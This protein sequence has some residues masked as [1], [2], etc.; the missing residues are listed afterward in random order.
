VLHRLDHPHHHLARI[1]LATLLAVSSTASVL[2]ASPAAALE[3]PRPLPG[4]RPAFVTEVQP[5]KWE[6]CLWASAAMLLDKWTS[7]RLGTG[8][9]RLRALSGD[10]VG[11]S[12][13]ADVARAYA[14]VGIPFRY[15]PNGGDR[16]TWAQLLVRLSRGAGAVILGDD[17]ELPRR[18][19]RWDPKFWKK[20]GKD[21]NHA[22]YV[23][24]YDRR[25]GRVWLMDP[26]ARGAWTG[27]WI[28]VR[29]LRRFAWTSGGAVYAATTPTA[30]PAPFAGVRFGAPE[31][32]AGATGLH[33]TWPAGAP[34]GWAFPGADVSAQ[35]TPLAD[36]IR[37]AVD[38]AVGGANVARDDDPV[39]APSVSYRQH[40]L[41]AS[42]PFP[43]TP[44]A[45]GVAIQVLDRRFGR[46]VGG[47]AIV[48]VFVPGD[49]AAR[50]TLAPIDGEVLPG[51]PITVSLVVANTGTVSWADD[52]RA[53][54][55]PATAPR[56]RSTHVVATWVPVLL[57][58]GARSG[59]GAAHA[60]PVVAVPLAAGHG[61]AAT[62]R[63]TAPLTGGTWALVFDVE[64]AIDGSFAAAGSAPAVAIV[65]VQGPPTDTPVK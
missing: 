6:D 50:I 27:E 11:G 44:G 60:T 20:T 5:G 63:L 29:A 7:G 32:A 35:F 28:S 19:G 2:V 13:F 14:R 15:S 24:R 26:L 1:V 39:S 45:Y 33:A 53:P 36:P 61:V 3:P 23:E 48:D 18:Y 21:D 55:L 46:P 34:R 64:D 38:L 47:A 52:R 42:V 30:R 16:L 37:A 17:H 62:A 43:S 65:A 8:R 49:R 57:D 9:D 54:D 56:R 40:A 58:A 59:R 4:Y 10:H 12:T 41:T 25:T 31:V 51:S 22:V